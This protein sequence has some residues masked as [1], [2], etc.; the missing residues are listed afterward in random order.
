M[1][2]VKCYTQHIHTLKGNDELEVIHSKHGNSS[3]RD[4]PSG[5]SVLTGRGAPKT[6]PESS[7]SLL[8]TGTLAS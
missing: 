2:I 1:L 5:S 6:H 3:N 8:L 7:A 4:T